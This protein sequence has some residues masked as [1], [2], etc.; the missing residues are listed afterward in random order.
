MI[1]WRLAAAAELEEVV[2]EHFPGRHRLA[3]PRAFRLT[4]EVQHFIGVLPQLTHDSILKLEVPVRQ[5]RTALQEVIGHTV[6]FA[7]IGGVADRVHADAMP[8][9]RLLVSDLDDAPLD[10]AAEA[11]QYRQCADA[12]VADVHRY[13]PSRDR[14]A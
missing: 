1:Q 12:D 13:S 2:R 6:H 9:P 8:T 10:G 14:L 5:T 11:K 4:V 3:H 7:P